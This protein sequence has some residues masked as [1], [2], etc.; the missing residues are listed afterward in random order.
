MYLDCVNYIQYVQLM[1]VCG[2]GTCTQVLMILRMILI[3]VISKKPGLGATGSGHPQL[4]R[5]VFPAP[6]ILS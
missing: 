6:P 2:M 5:S 3:L 1:Y 4:P